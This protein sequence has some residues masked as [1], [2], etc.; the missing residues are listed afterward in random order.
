M[1]KWIDVQDLI[2]NNT[3]LILF[4]LIVFVIVYFYYLNNL[5]DQKERDN[6]KFNMMFV[7]FVIV[8]F[9]L[10]VVLV[11]LPSQI[12]RHNQDLVET[13]NTS[14]YNVTLFSKGWAEYMTREA[15]KMIEA[16]RTEFDRTMQ[17]ITNQSG[18]ARLLYGKRYKPPARARLTPGE[19]PD[20]Q[21]I[22]PEYI[23]DANPTT[24]TPL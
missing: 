22:H 13:I 19:F 12:R 1:L 16:L 17:Q 2:S 14:T 4:P 5:K 7:F 3:G 8:T 9:S 15:F 6:H 18:F 11:K 21:W 24:P 10:I 23:R 20:L